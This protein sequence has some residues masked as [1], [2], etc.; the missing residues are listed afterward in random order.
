MG[1]HTRFRLLTAVLLI[2]ISDAFAVVLF[3]STGIYIDKDRRV[4]QPSAKR[5]KTV[6]APAGAIGMLEIIQ[7][8]GAA[9]T[10]VSNY[11]A[12]G[13]EGPVM[14]LLMSYFP[15]TREDML[16][17][18]R[19]ILLA[20][21]AHLHLR[22]IIR[23]CTPPYTLCSS[24]D[25][26]G[27]DVDDF[28]ALSSCCLDPG[29]SRRMHAELHK[30]RQ[31]HFEAQRLLHFLKQMHSCWQAAVRPTTQKEEFHHAHNKV[32]SKGQDGAA[33]AHCHVAAAHVCNC[34]RTAFVQMGNRDSATTPV[35]TLKESFK[36][37]VSTPKHKRP[38]QVGSHS[39]VW[40]ARQAQ[41][42]LQQAN[43]N[44]TKAELES[45]F[46]GVWASMSERDK[47]SIKDAHVVSVISRR[48]QEADAT[49]LKS[50]KQNQKQALSTPWNL[51][52]HDYPLDADSVREYLLQFKDRE[53]TL[54][55]FRECGMG[56]HRILPLLNQSYWV[57][58]KAASVYQRF[59][60]ESVISAARSEDSTT[61][62]FLSDHEG[63]TWK[64]AADLY[65]ESG[66]K[67]HNCYRD[68]YGVCQTQHASIYQ[69]V[70]AIAT[71]LEC[72]IR[73]FPVEDCRPWNQQ[74]QF[75]SD[76][77]LTL[78][79]WLCHG[80]LRPAEPIFLLQE[81][82]RD[83]AVCVGEGQ[84]Q[85]G[86]YPSASVQLPLVLCS[87]RCHLKPRNASKTADRPLVIW[88]VTQHELSLQLAKNSKT[89][90]VSVLKAIC[91]LNSCD[92]LTA[93]EVVVKKSLA[94][95]RA[96][97]VVRTPFNA[98][99]CS[100]QASKRCSKQGVKQQRTPSRLKASRNVR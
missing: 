82:V 71:S 80:K 60:F 10:S 8:C 96:K 69:D 70:M 97:T 12:C 32:I 20:V 56:E 50:Q 35:A 13:F 72:M 52:T 53:E 37:A 99:D 40:V 31:R 77:G 23:F 84:H 38:N 67:M 28:M 66:G 55:M 39:L 81:P 45:H 25:M 4:E 94:E 54:K 98:E 5:H 58:S 79:C 46:Q 74:L 83:A 41:E 64:L 87:A 89:W 95:L 65:E 51:G 24:E 44:Q 19:C 61:E 15:G 34:L 29:C 17:Q 78:F 68:H 86:I 3:T 76:D 18:L 48:V 36:A 85:I 49:K 14:K 27:Q 90:S 73:K 91:N 22:F 57:A 62:S 43:C 42:A 26:T 59:E 7:S 9:F 33:L 1:P 2:R 100:K 88:L 30:M 21:A 6:R 93:Q 16:M 11:L 63:S 47:K 75:E 92:K